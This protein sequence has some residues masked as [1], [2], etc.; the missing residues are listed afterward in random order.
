MTPSGTISSDPKRKRKKGDTIYCQKELKNIE[1]RV[2]W[3]LAE[4]S[5]TK[6]GAKDK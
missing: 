6:K 1:N 4:L 2:A 3:F 5:K